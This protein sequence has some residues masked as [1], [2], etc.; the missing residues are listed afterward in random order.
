M[1]FLFSVFDVHRLKRT[2]QEDI[3]QAK[4]HADA[5]HTADRL[6]L[7]S[8]ATMKT[9]GC[10]TIGIFVCVQHDVYIYIY[11]YIYSYIYIYIFLVFGHLIGARIIIHGMLDF[12]ANRSTQTGV[13]SLRFLVGIALFGGC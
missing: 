6:R 10:A 4:C 12:Q 9:V 2:P 3:G 1:E 5:E 13:S 11:I 8:W 7:R